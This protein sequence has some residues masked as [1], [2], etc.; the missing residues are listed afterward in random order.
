[1]SFS[2]KQNEGNARE[3]LR[4]FWAGSSLG[5]PALYVV[6]DQPDFTERPWRGF[7]LDAKGRDL[8]PEWHAWCAERALAGTVYLAEAMPAAVLVWGGYLTTLATLAGA[9][10]EYHSDSAWVRPIPDLWEQPLPVFDPEH[11]TAKSYELCIRRV[12]EVVGR[13]GFVNPAVMLDPLTTLSQFRTPEQLCLD[14][15]EA[16]DHVRR[17]SDA[18][19]SLYIAVYEHYYRVVESLG[20]GDTTTWLQA[21][22][23]GRMESLQCDFAIM[24]SPDMFDRFVMPDLRRLTEALD[25]SLYHLD[26]T[27]QMR[28]LDSLRKLPRLNG[29]QWNPEPPAGSPVLWIEAFREIRRRGFCLHIHCPTVEEAVVI[30]K[31]LGPDGLLLALPRFKT[32]AEAEAAIRALEHCV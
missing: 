6:A 15:V 31:A 28:F 26:G 27:S 22:A 1:M 25:F 19:T 32:V 4:A 14:V 12:A 9:D 29:I 23:E 2:L 18:L 3:R 24:L 11:P 7:E 5:R 8:L 20:Y 10:Y 21:M 16:P 13:R 30:A 17:W